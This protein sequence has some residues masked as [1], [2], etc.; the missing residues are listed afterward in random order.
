[1]TR[2]ELIINKVD[3]KVDLSEEEIETLLWE[4]DEVS[5]EMGEPHRW[6]TPVSTVIE[7]LGRYFQINWWRGNTE[8]QM[9]IYSEQPYEVEPYEETITITKYRRI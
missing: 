2:I 8:Y 7:V 1:M 5:V 9:D 6:N 3:S 4:T